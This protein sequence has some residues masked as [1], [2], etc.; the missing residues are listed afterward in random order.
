MLF[1]H[2][3]SFLNKIKCKFGAYCCQNST[4]TKM[5]YC[6]VGNPGSFLNIPIRGKGNGERKRTFYL[7][8]P[9]TSD[10]NDLTCNKTPFCLLYINIFLIQIILDKH[11]T[12]FILTTLWT[13]K[14]I[15]KNVFFLL[16]IPKVN[17]LYSIIVHKHKNHSWNHKKNLKIV[18]T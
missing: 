8:K 2:Q 14:V 17:V 9:C 16:N 15:S 11:S 1:R 12:Q 7:N 5:Q 4:R 6:L 18:I 13:W 3:F 10:T